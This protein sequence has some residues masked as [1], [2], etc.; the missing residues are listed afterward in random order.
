MCLL[1]ANMVKLQ[2]K[3]IHFTAIILVMLQLSDAFFNRNV[4]SL[5]TGGP[6]G[7]AIKPV[8]NP[9]NLKVEGWFATASGDRDPKILPSL[10]VRDIIT[11]GIVVNDHT[12]L[13]EPEDMVRLK[14]VL[15]IEFALKGKK[16]YTENKKLIGKIQDYSIDDK[17]FLIKKLY[18]T[19]SLL[20]G[21]AKQDIIIDR[22][23]I[24]EIT[25]KKIIISE[26]SEKVSDRS[27]ATAPAA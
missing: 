25:D 26:P 27:P 4:L 6:I 20:R 15:E 24:I 11:K 23:Q 10:E 14:D 7:Q 21:I 19:Q 3:L 22:N 13:T 17:S 9:N 8:I 12:S 5:R 2:G 16:V 1:W 18:A